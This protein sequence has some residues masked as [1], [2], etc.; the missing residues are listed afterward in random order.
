MN[1]C[2]EPYR[3]KYAGQTALF[4]G[5]GPSLLEW[6]ERRNGIEFGCNEIIHRRVVDFYFI[7]DQGNKKRGYLS[8][9]AAYKAYRPRVEKF[10]RKNTTA[11][12]P[13]NHK[14]VQYYECTDR[15]KRAPYKF[16]ADVTRGIGFGYSISFEVM[17]FII[18][19]GFA[20]CI[21]IGHDCNYSAGTFNSPKATQVNGDGIKR[22]WD[23]FEIW[24][25]ENKIPLRVLSF[26]PIGLKG[27][28]EEL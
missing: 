15:V 28:F 1:S 7:G 23:R 3:N 12:M 11:H 18:F 26:H 9:E 13:Y 17:Q 10:Y 6:D 25:V 4:F 19:C 27:T 5:T 8:N 2:F 21:L 24:R 16:H 14:D 22:Q 20:E